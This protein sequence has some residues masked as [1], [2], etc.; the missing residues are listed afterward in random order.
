MSSHGKGVLEASQVG[1]YI[2]EYEIGRGSFATVY[3]GYH[4]VGLAPISLIIPWQTWVGISLSLFLGPTLHRVKPFQLL[5][6]CIP[7]TNTPSLKRMARLMD[8]TLYIN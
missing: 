6:T 5:L 3:K 7:T 1:D 4:K 8:G 2:V